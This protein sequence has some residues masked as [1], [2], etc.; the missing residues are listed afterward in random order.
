MPKF[1]YTA[2][3]K[4]GKS[5]SGSTEAI[6]RQSL[7]DSLAK[8]GARPLLIKMDTGGKALLG[9]KL[10]VSSQKVKLK[11]LVIFSRQMST[12]I[13]AGVPLTRALQTMQNQTTNK[14]FKTVIG[15]IAKDVEGGISLGE[16]FGKYP[17]VF[18]EIYINMIKAGESGG[19]LDDILK[20]LASQVEQEAMMRKKIKGAMMYP[21]VIM[22]VTV[23][24]FFGITMFVLPKIGKI[25]TDL[26]GPNAKLPIYTIA[27]LKLSDFMQHHG[28]FIVIGLVVF[29]LLFRRYIRT[30]KGKYNWHATLLRMP[31]LKDI[32]I[33]I[34]IARFARTFAALMTSGV[35][36]L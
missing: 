9:G 13:S 7:I 29:S 25:L 26:G 16:A 20:R 32:L 34:A 21:M 10:T 22:S 6:S 36:R 1:T 2:V 12:M 30:P 15:G 23:I 18:S 4:E 5:F 31:I 19:I 24:A 28:V 35:N 33:K 3:N 27:M 17:K 8:Q 14:Y 11:D